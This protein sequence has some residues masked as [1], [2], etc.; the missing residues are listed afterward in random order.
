M[1]MANRWQWSKSNSCA[2][3]KSTER[4]SPPQANT[5]FTNDLGPNTVGRPPSGKCYI[6]AENFEGLPPA[7][8]AKEEYVPV[9]YP[10]A[11][12]VTAAIPLDVAAGTQVRAGDMILHKAPTATV[13]GR[14]AIELPDAHGT[15]SVSFF[16]KAGH[17]NSAA[18]SFRAPSA[19]VNAAGGFEIRSL[20][21]G[22]YTVMAEISK[23]GQR[24]YRPDH[25]GCGRDQHRRRRCH[26]R[27][28]RFPDGRDSCRR[29]NHAEFA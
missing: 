13:K 1:P 3:K 29:R 24:F 8:V 9:Y 23:G 11:T 17:N 20:T 10:D 22:S 16:P 18:G 27:K 15:P 4:R 28:W 7:S 6:Y 5:A 25:G 26:Y 21:P 14:V 2:P 12:N 19:K